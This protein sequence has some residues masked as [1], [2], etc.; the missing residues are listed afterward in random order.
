MTKKPAIWA[1]EMSRCG[2]Y[3]A[4]AGHDGVVRVWAAH[5]S[6]D[7]PNAQNGDAPAEASVLAEKSCKRRL[8]AFSLP[9]QAP[10]FDPKPLHEYVGHT[11]DVLDISWS[12]VRRR[13]CRHC[14]E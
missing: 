6:T 3:L 8:R 10:V 5:S 14:L 7:D 11:A 12:K 2:R 13:S 4:A 9:Y 1:M